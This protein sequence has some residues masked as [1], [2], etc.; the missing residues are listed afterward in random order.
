MTAA[1]LSIIV[2]VL[3]EAKGIEASLEYLL[4]AIYD[5]KQTQ[6]IVVDGGSTDNTLQ[7]VQTFAKEHPNLQINC[8][9]CEKGRARQMN[10][11]AQKAQGKLLY[12][13]HADSLPPRGFDSLI[14]EAYAQGKTAGCFRLQFDSRHWWLRLAGWFTKFNW[15]AC[16]GGDQSLFI[17]KALFKSLGEYNEQ[18]QIYEDNLLIAQLY[19]S[20]QFWVLPE[21]I[22]TSARL[23]RKRGVWA[24]QFYFWMIYLKKKMGA[25]PEALYDYY[26]TKIVRAN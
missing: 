17:S 24:V 16:R 18:Y 13:L 23:Y 1:R 7:L 2:P 12:F 21:R 15:K 8:Y 19:K 22:T 10:F 14:V 11:G 20:N 26:Q 3:N 25:S 4:G 6:L 9:N 5:I